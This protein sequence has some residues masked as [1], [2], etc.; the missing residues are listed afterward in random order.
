MIPASVGPS[1]S[2]PGSAAVWAAK[3]VPGRHGAAMAASGESCRHR[4][5]GL[6]SLTDPDLPPEPK[7]TFTSPETGWTGNLMARKVLNS[8]F[9]TAIVLYVWHPH[10]P[11]YGLSVLSMGCQ[12]TATYRSPRFL[13]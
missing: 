4:W 9:L 3:L 8:Y 6:E 13:P 1:E 7:R 11:M 2:W 10:V 12:K 5:H